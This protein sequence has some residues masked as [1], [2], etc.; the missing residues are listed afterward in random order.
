MFLNDTIA[1]ISTPLGEG[2]IGIVRLSGKDSI[3]LAE[4]IFKSPFNKRL[5]EAKSHTLTLGFVTDPETQSTIDEALF[6]VM[7]SPKTYTRED[8]VEINCHGGILPL[9]TTLNLLLKNGAR[10]AEPGE[11]TKRAFLNGRI[12]LSQA[13]AVIDII[14]AKTQ[15][16][17]RIALTQ[18][19]GRLSEKIKCLIE[20]IICLCANVEAYIDFPE[21]EIEEIKGE[22]LSQRI[23]NLKKN[24]HELAASYDEGRFFK[25]GVSTA[26][27][28]KPNVGKSSLLNCLLEKDRAI[29]TTSPGTTRD[30]IEDYLNI[31]GLPL[32]IMDTAGIREPQELAEMEGVIRS[33]KAIENSDIVMA[34]F[35]LSAPLD[36]LD[37]EIFQKIKDKKALIILNKLDIESHQFNFADMGITSEQCMKISALKSIGIK[38]LKDKVYSLC[39][40]KKE[41][42]QTEDILISNMRHKDSIEKAI[43]SLDE[44]EEL[45]KHNEVVEIIAMLLREAGDSLGEIPG[46]VISENVLNKIFREF[47]IGK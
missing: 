8:I 7:K 30:I 45:L 41:S 11:F 12:D 38:E 43:K 16:A 17:E 25:E 22:E 42:G 36:S 40:S 32:R 9:R 33:L 31:N 37:I 13:E 2:G 6:T 21:D 23:N 3:I 44:A 4:K 1:A 34:V 14:R 26:I 10:L 24:L 28:G 39:I 5:S 46:S 18:L 29:V 27:V 35:D 19:E 15:R 47:C 20:E